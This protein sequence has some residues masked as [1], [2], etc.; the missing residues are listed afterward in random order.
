M[1]I[2]MLGQ[3]VFVL[4][5]EGARR[6]WGGW[7]CPQY[8]LYFEQMG[9]GDDLTSHYYINNVQVV[10]CQPQCLVLPQHKCQIDTTHPSPYQHQ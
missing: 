7:E 5:Y 8:Y 10:A 2:R 6:F 3:S 1:M 4:V 9:I